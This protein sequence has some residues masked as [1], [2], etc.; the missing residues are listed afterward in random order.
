MPRPSAP[1]RRHAACFVADTM[2][3]SPST[4]PDASFPPPQ[5]FE[6]ETVRA[7]LWRELRAATNSLWHS[8]RYGV[9]AFLSVALG[10]GASLAVFAVFSALTLRA[11]PFPEPGQLVTVGFPGA[12]EW[13]GPDALT[14]THPLVAQ[15]REHRSIFESLTARRNLSARL[16][17]EGRLPLWT[18]GARVSADFFDTLGTTAEQGRT[19]SARDT[20]SEGLDVVVL[21]RGFWLEQFGGAPLLGKAV[22][23]NA[24]PKTV[25]GIISDEQG[26]PSWTDVYYPV[27]LA[28]DVQPQ[29]FVFDATARL[30]KGVTPAMAQERLAQ[31]TADLDVRNPARERLGVR[32][33][34]LRETLVRAERSWLHLMLAA[35]LSF[36]A[37]ACAN[38][39]ALLATRAAVRQRERA[40]CSALGASRR[41]LAGQSLLEAIVVVLA[42]SL[43]GVGLAQ[44][45]ISLANEHYADVLGN[46][47]ARIDRWVLVALFALI[48]LCTLAG[49]AVPVLATRRVRPMDALAGAARA[50]EGRAAT[51]SRALLVA[52]QV[53]VTVVL[54]VGAGLLVRSLQATLAT[55]PGFDT[56][57][58]VTASV[59][60]S[61]PPHDGTAASFLAQL[62]NGRRQVQPLLEHLRAL[63]GVLGATLGSDL[64]FDY[65]NETLTLELEPEAT[66]QTLPV[67]IHS[68]GPDHFETLG[69]RLISGRVFSPVEQRAWPPQS[70]AIVS[71]SLARE[72]LG[73]EDA[74]G[75]RVRFSSPGGTYEMPWIEII[76]MVESTREVSLTEPAP[77]SLYFPFF[78]YP[79]RSVNQGNVRVAVALKVSGSPEATMARLPASVAEVIPGAPVNDLK[80]LATWLGESHARRTAL[81]QVLSTLALAALVL[82][83]IGIFGIT[84]YSVARRTSE[85]GIRR[86]LGASRRAIRRM[87]LLETGRVVACGL[88][89]G[90][91]GAWFA[92]RLLD[93]FLFGVAALDPLTYGGVSLGTAVATSTAALLAARSAAR[94]EP[95]R[96]LAG[97]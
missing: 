23:V 66:H 56:T 95:S 50:S 44:L 7:S 70:V 4:G 9:P 21:R 11:L 19:F 73:V 15:F 75:H 74:V 89:V 36:L 47:P 39:A 38:L 37:L 92:R 53:A 97:R 55:D 71:Q 14:M 80:T 84:S 12:S 82:S 94:I 42:G 40:V 52:L 86:A 10:T 28:E 49:S 79:T 69:I 60:L 87:I 45:G 35:V 72:G 18:S 31:L 5:T 57:G 6:R 3:P 33:T 65:H 63:P 8:P 61:V 88:L 59:V 48:T 1:G 30:A 29:S 25:I 20:G 93:G 46:T 85:I 43:A 96:A 2:A 24:L 76:G 26:L 62:E 41:W 81:S 16:E 68:V 64:P 13:S 34:P 83:V 27:N 51:R 58:V 54:L 67:S 91:L 90:L 78:A 77:P 32:V 22:L 17:V